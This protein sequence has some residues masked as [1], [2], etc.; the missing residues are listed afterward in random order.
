MLEC[1]NHVGI[2]PVRISMNVERFAPPRNSCVIEASSESPLDHILK[3]GVQAAWRR[4]SESLLGRALRIFRKEACVVADADIYVA[5]LPDVCSCFVRTLSEHRNVESGER[6][7]PVD[8]LLYNRFRIRAFIG[9]G[10]GRP[11]RP[12]RECIFGN[13]LRL[14]AGEFL[15]KDRLPQAGCA[16]NSCR[17]RCLQLLHHG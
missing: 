8:R 2:D 11:L 4:H 1:W 7:V 10:C 13:V 5:L 12:E 6:L 14:R 17:E 15:L 3:V 9:F 16:L